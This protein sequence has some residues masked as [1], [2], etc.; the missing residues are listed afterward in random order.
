[1]GNDEDETDD[2][3]TR[4]R[5][6]IPDRRKHT[7]QQLEDRLDKHIDAI[8]ERFERWFKRGLIA[9]A[10]I[11]LATATALGGFGYLLYDQKQD[12]LAACENVNVRHNNAI[13][14]LIAG[15]N[16]DQLN[17]KTPEA[18]LE[19]QRRRD[20]TIGLIDAVLPV[21]D[22]ANPDKVKPLP[23]VTPIP[24]E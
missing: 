5:L 1:M 4:R 9:F 15:S 6:A 20:V 24:E 11:G 12:A 13:N 8:E 14:A 21:T 17:A 18:R 2:N 22:C 10:L 7:Y 19:I 23:E 16:E 3:G